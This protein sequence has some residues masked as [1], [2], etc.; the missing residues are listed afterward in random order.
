MV[1]LVGELGWGW[2]QEGDMGPFAAGCG[3]GCARGEW[4]YVPLVG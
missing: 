2:G 3:S 4:N 1:L